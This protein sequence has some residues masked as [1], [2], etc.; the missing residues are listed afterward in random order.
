MASIFKKVRKLAL[1]AGAEIATR[2]GQKIARWTDGKG[3][4]RT[5]PLS[6][7]G[8][9]VEI[10]RPGWF[11]KYRGSDGKWHETNGGKDREAVKE[12]QRRSR[13]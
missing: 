8:A 4:N 6:D 2:K 3:R 5:A 10:E 11:I 13:Y 12:T 1:P 9:N 7:D